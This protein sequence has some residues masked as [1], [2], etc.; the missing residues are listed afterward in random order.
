MTT[1]SERFRE[2]NRLAG[3]IAMN[4]YD[5]FWAKDRFHFGNPAVEYE[6]I[7]S[8]EGQELGIAPGDDPYWTGLR[9]TSDGQVFEIE[10]D[11]IALAAKAPSPAERRE[12]S[13]QQELPA[14]TS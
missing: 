4:L 2:S 14:V 6:L 12:V 3:S 11:V 10:I 13:G 8:D 7:G 5:G 9:R 1:D